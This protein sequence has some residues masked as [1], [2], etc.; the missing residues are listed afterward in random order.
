M[1]VY[2]TE[3]C[4]HEDRFRANH[5]FTDICLHTVSKYDTGN[6][7]D[8]FLSLIMYVCTLFDVFYIA[9]HGY[10]GHR[11]FKSKFKKNII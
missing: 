9:D 11:W 1:F 4:I 10:P 5:F 8:S 2:A 3:Q 7:R 6:T